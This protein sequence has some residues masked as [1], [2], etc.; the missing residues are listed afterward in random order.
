MIV[1]PQTWRFFTM[2]QFSLLI[3]ASQPSFSWL[4]KNLNL[5]FLSF[6]VLVVGCYLSWIDPRACFVPY[7]TITKTSITTRIWIIKH[8]QAR[9]WIDILFHVLPFFYA[10]AYFGPPHIQWRTTVGSALL[11]CL[12]LCLFSIHN[13]YHLPFINVFCVGLFSIFLFI[14]IC[15][16]ED[17]TLSSSSSSYVTA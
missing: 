5:P 11:L 3:L 12:Y 14:I 16:M 9:L 1:I 10:L 13:V 17:V 7:Y 6:F 8:W 2:W 4:S 15:I